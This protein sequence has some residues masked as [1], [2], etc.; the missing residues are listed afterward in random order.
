MDLNR[1]YIWTEHSCQYR[2]NYLADQEK[3]KA[4]SKKLDELTI[5][6]GDSQRAICLLEGKL[7]GLSTKASEL[8]RLVQEPRQP[9]PAIHFLILT[10]NILSQ[11]HPKI[12]KG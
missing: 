8:I 1:S 9:S 4:L 5:I 11:L 2:S 3:V 12:L 10:L 7:S 6:Y